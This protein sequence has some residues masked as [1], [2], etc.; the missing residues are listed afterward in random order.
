MKI[1]LKHTNMIKIEYY[2]EVSYC[3]DSMFEIQTR[4]ASVCMYVLQQSVCVS[5]Q[6]CQHK[7]LA[8]L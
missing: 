5:G 1:N 7:I 6:I 8:D 3:L 2:L 4:S